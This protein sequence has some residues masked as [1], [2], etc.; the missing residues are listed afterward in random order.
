MSYVK[1]P[2]IGIKLNLLVIDC[3]TDLKLPD[4]SQAV[5]LKIYL[6]DVQTHVYNM[7]STGAV[8]TSTWIAFQCIAKVSAVQIM[9]PEI[10][11]APT[12]NKNKQ[13]SLDYLKE[14]KKKN[15]KKTHTQ[16]SGNGLIG[17]TKNVPINSSVNH[18][19]ISQL[20]KK[21]KTFYHLLL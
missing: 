18:K 12:G 10:V 14:R 20:H 6:N 1:Q 21:Y 3:I 7:F 9:I 17:K 16:S 19:Y 11:M 4:I 2:Y 5:F 8:I 15:G 13:N